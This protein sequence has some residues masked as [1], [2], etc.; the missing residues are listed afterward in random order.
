VA[1]TSCR[2]RSSAVICASNACRRKA[3]RRHP[4]GRH[5]T[6]R[7]PTGRH[8]T[9]R[10]PTGASVP[11]AG[12]CSIRHLVPGESAA[13]PAAGRLV[14]GRSSG[15]NFSECKRGGLYRPSRSAMPGVSIGVSRATAVNP[16]SSAC[17][18]PG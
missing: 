15:T 8:P 10:H 7:H 11:R 3:P 16:G 5:P 13:D 14:G 12:D 1:A 9:G 2:I 6:G 18:P 4:T 17:G